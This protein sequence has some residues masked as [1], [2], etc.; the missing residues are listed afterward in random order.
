[1]KR[2]LIIL[3]CLLPFTLFGQKQFIRNSITSDTIYFYRGVSLLKLPRDITKVNKN[4]GSTTGTLTTAALNVGGKDLSVDSISYVD[5]KYALWDGVDTISPHIN[6]NDQVDINDIVFNKL[7]VGDASSNTLVT[8]DS[9]GYDQNGDY[10]VYNEMGD[11]LSAHI[12]YAD[13]VDITDA[14]VMLSDSV[15]SGAHTYTS[16][17]DF[18]TGQ[19]L[20]VNIADST[21]NDS[22]N[23]M[24]RQNYH[25]DPSV[26]N[27]LK[28]LKGVGTTIKALPISPPFAYISNK[29]PTD[30]Q[31]TYLLFYIPE[32]TTITGVS[33]QQVTQGNYT[34]DNFNGFALYSVATST[35]VITQVAVTADAATLFNASGN[36]KTIAF[37]SPYVASPGYYC[38]GFLYNESAHT[39]VP[40]FQGISTN[41][42]MINTSLAHNIKITAIRETQTALP[43]PTDDYANFDSTTASIYI[44]LY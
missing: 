38:T 21:N 22:G 19:A 2:I 27:T 17:K 16:G 11:S 18:Q 23:Y 37:T 29:T 6:T 39:T 20:K 32:T 42:L 40:V 35:G 12:N 13:L 36:T 3:L 44:F 15:G 14:V 33:F 31:A 5:G 8:I 10:T 41:I 7:R 28:E 30:G 1:M 24:T 25:N 34:A 43:N 26:T 9:I 4:N